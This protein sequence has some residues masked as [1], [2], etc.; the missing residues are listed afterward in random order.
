V[1]KSEPVN[2]VVET[3]AGSRNKYRF[4]E[5]TGSFLLHKVL[6]LGFSFPFDFGFL[7]GTHAEDG[8]PIDVV[9][10]GG[11][12][13]FTGCV[14]PARILGVIEAEQRE[15][16]KTIRND[17]V[18]ATAE[19][20]KI[21]PPWDDLGD[22]PGKLLD[23]VERFFVAYNEGEGRLFAPIGRRGTAAAWKSIEEARKARGTS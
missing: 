21:R 9:L 1:P 7:P 2:V 11:E 3:P 20:A 17:R 13:T 5:S 10:L 15:S 18:I 23:E 4:D 12:P 16:G 8:D 22:V 14:V 19:T 6:P